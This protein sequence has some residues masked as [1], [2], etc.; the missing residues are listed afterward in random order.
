MIPQRAKARVLSSRLRSRMPR[1]RKVE[2]Y[3]L[4]I[5]RA[6]VILLLLWPL[7]ARHVTSKQR[8][9]HD[10]GSDVHSRIKL[11]RIDRA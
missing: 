7:A 8:S 1:M 5:V 3:Y 6:R 9:L 2:R 10:S 11:I 4:K